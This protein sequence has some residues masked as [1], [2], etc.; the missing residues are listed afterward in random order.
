LFYSKEQCAG[1]FNHALLGLAEV[2]YA[3]HDSTASA[4]AQ[5]VAEQFRA[6][7]EFDEDAEATA[8]IVK[9]SFE[10]GHAVATCEASAPHLN[11]LLQT[12]EVSS[13]RIDSL[14]AIAQCEALAGNPGYAEKL[15][16]ALNVAKEIGSFGQ[17][18]EA[19]LVADDLNSDS[20]AR[21][22]SLE[23]VRQK[24][25]AKGFERIAA[26][27]QQMEGQRSVRLVA[28]FRGAAH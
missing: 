4:Q 28:G 19:V 17:N 16:E 20:G 3:Q 7:N 13:A 5:T 8:L 21:R 27:A 26:E 2:A 23:Q 15:N 11:Q 24:A 10:G 12:L 14:L 9:T 18:L 22:Q 1:A 25:A 6:E